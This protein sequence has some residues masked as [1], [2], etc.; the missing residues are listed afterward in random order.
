LKTLDVVGFVGE[1]E[2]AGP[3]V[4]AIDSI[5]LNRFLDEGEG[6]EA[7]AVKLATA[8]TISLEQR[9]GTDLEPGMHHAAVAATRAPAELVLLE[10]RDGAAAPRQARRRHDPGIASAYNDDIDLGR[11]RRRWACGG[12]SFAPPVGLLAIVRG[13]RCYG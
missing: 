12:R 2:V 3:R 9:D 6:V 10:Q 11:K 13:E 7:G 4:V 5:G 8:V 1:V